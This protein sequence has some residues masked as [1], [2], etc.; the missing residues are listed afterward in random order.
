M[1]LFIRFHQSVSKSI[2]MNFINDLPEYCFLI[3]TKSWGEMLLGQASRC[4]AQF[5]DDTT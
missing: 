1:V 5:S 3:I 4:V 2:L